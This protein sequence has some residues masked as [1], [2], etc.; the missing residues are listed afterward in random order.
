MSR[1]A[2]RLLS[3]RLDAAPMRPRSV[4][5]ALLALLL[6]GCLAPAG[7]PPPGA[8]SS[9]A[10]APDHAALDA[11]IG[12]PLVLDHD[13]TKGSLH[14]GGVNMRFVAWSSLGVTLGDNGF[15]NFVLWNG[16]G[17]ELAFVAVDGDARGGFVIADARDPLHIT[18]L[19]SYM[20]PGS[21][22]QEVRVFPDGRHALLNVQERPD[23]ASVVAA[24]GLGVCS[25]CI[26]VVNIE[27][28]TRPFLESALPVQLLGTH[29]MDIHAIGGELYVFYVGQLQGHP[30]EP[31]GNEIGVARYVETPLGAQLVP[32]GSYRH[33]QAAT[34]A[35]LS[36]P[37]DVDVHEHALT[38]QQIM[39]VSHWE[40]GAVTVDVT[41]PS[42]PR[43]L[44]VEADPAPSA[45]AN[46]H[47]FAPE[48]RPRGDRLFAWSAPEIQGLDTGSGVIRAYD[49]SDPAAFEQVGTWTLPGRVIIP[50]AFLFSPHTTM[51]DMDRGIMAVSH[52]HAGVWVLDIS[53]PKE[54]RALGYYLPHGDPAA[55][56]DGPIWWKKP[57]FDPD[58]FFPN[59][60]Q[61]RWK[62]GLLWVTERGTGLY[63]LEYTGPVPGRIG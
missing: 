21:G 37:H 52:Y 3:P 57:N 56:Y 43:E 10:G 63:V 47:W 18:P 60:Y 4:A 40:G 1:A 7:A 53:D 50:G 27:D 55:P 26:H 9:P 5:T 62:D 44:H 35:G 51:P 54:P 25:V 24:P 28:R 59:V 17:E 33:P 39:Y 36:F 8:P 23:P 13:H 2:R 29:N 46:I 41:D 11:L 19:G 6:A 58:G 14:T 15:A 49:V 32:V 22:F 20:V 42:A 61:A 16:S 31:V 34:E 38:H 48:E 30:K 12:A 45:V